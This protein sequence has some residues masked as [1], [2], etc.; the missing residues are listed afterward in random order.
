M[1]C[2]HIIILQFSRWEIK[3]V[4]GGKIYLEVQNQAGGCKLKLGGT[5]WAKPDMHFQWAEFWGG[6]PVKYCNMAFLYN[7]TDIRAK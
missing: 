4:T 2:L 3:N 1:F 6:S 7:N 5:N